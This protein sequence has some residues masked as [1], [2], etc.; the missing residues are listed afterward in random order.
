MA[1]LEPKKKIFIDVTQVIEIGHWL[2]ADE[3]A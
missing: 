2:C 3:R 1:L